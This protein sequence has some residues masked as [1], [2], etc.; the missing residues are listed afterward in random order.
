MQGA[1]DMQK[2]VHMP[3]LAHRMLEL[4]SYFLEQRSGSGKTKAHKNLNLDIKPGTNMQK[5]VHMTNTYS[6]W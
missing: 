1:T 3:D 6:K 2:S 4:G 5:S